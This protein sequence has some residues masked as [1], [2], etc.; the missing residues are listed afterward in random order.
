MSYTLKVNL[1][2]EYDIQ[3]AYG[4]YELKS[5]GLGEFFLSEIETVLNLLTRPQNLFKNGIEK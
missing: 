5:I 2:A 3:D 4:W 1:Q